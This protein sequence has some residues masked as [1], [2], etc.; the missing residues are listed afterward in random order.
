LLLPGVVILIV[1]LISTM[2]GQVSGKALFS[3]EW[4]TVMFS[5]AIALYAFR[6][7]RKA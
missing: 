1:L 5:L 4:I 3:V 6:V 7:R 2:V